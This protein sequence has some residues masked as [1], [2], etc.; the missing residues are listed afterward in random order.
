LSD[1]EYEVASSI[2]SKAIALDG[3][4]WQ[5]FMHRALCKIHLQ[6]FKLALRDIDHVLILHKFSPDTWVLRAKLRWYLGNIP[7]GNGDFRR[8]H[9]LDPR[10][11]EVIVFEE[12]LWKNADIAYR[13]A[14]G[15]IMT[16]NYTR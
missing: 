14:S 6:K 4:C 7:A 8:A 1:G 12:L 15:A 2:F 11:P 13:E 16:K 9:A 10:H 3:L 5:Y